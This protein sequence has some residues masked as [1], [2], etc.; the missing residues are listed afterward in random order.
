MRTMSD[1]VNESRE[2]ESS[3]GID[4]GGDIGDAEWSFV[5]TYRDVKEASWKSFFCVRGCWGG[6]VG[7]PFPPEE[8]G[9]AI[10]GVNGERER[11]RSRNDIDIDTVSRCR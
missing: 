4:R 2:R 10:G 5:V 7:V 6:E 9:D 11:K 8:V 1:L 3:S